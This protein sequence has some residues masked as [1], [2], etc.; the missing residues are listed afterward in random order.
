MERVTLILSPQFLPLPRPE[1]PEFRQVIFDIV[2]FNFSI[3]QGTLQNEPVESVLYSA[4]F[5]LFND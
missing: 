2:K 3:L 4:L 1:I 5:S